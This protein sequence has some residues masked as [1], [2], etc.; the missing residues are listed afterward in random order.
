V[1]EYVDFLARQPPYDRLGADDLEE[2]GRHVRVEF[3][4]AGAVIVGANE[5]RL[6]HLSVIRTGQVHVIDRG[7]VVDELGPG[8]TF[9]QISVL[10]GL[11][12]A[13]SVVAATD[14][15]CYHI[16]DPRG[17]LR[18]PQR[19]TF[20]HY[21]TMVARPRA[22]SA[23]ADY[24]LRS[25]GEFMRPALWC[26]AETPVRDAARRMSQEHQS[27]I[28]YDSPD[29][30]GIMT[31]SDCRRQVATG[32]VPVDA[33]VHRVGTVP[34][35]TVG[36][37]VPAATAFLEMIHRGVHHLVVVDSGGRPAG[38]VRVF[39]LSTAD[40]RDPLT[41]RA[42]VD[43]ARTM[44]EL[45][46]AAAQIPP[47]TVELF[48]SG[49]AATRVA[50]LMA[51]I[52]EAVVV[53]CAGYSD[54]F[55]PDRP[56]L[57]T[58]WLVLG[59]LARREPL[60][61]SD[62][63][64]A[65]IWQ[66]RSGALDSRELTAAAETVIER[67]EECGLRR[68]PDGANASNPLFNRSYDAWVPAVRHWVADP[69]SEGALLLS[70]ILTD[71]RAV[72]GLHLGRALAEAVPRRPSRQFLQRMLDEALVHRPPTGFVRG[73][74]VEAGGRHRGQLD[75]KRGGLL[76]VVA[77]GRWIV[78]ATGERVASTQERLQL[79][80][81]EGILT[82]DEADILGGAHEEMFTMLFAREAKALS[83]RT[84]LTTHLDPRELDTLSRRHLRD[85]FRAIGKVQSRLESE[86]VS[87]VR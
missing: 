45:V 32:E 71:S 18:E 49:I 22:T 1:Q 54:V 15:L 78:V 34:A 40:I 46:A 62:V 20:S 77:L 6:D 61:Q 86:W 65:V 13:L 21:N 72:T 11:P 63:D 48:E 12:P 84:P 14:T 24:G 47:A 41:V 44:P 42:A 26:T 68:C 51:A 25:V 9:G 30:L 64:T 28:L 87:R 60:P 70:A 27:C 8:D 55:G 80:T 75:L 69:H 36:Q 43:N 53:K 50:A 59:S 10:S 83:S 81:A 31:D 79:G 58:S 57:T 17:F 52:T 66:P 35:A 74:V 67:A 3:F 29:G 56:D 2:L 7:R 5:P 4:T 82:Q 76:P 16:P 38:V 39:D 85:S 23:A 33:A 19:L 37:A 73:F